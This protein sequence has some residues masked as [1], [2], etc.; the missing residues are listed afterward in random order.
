MSFCRSTHEFASP[1]SLDKKHKRIFPLAFRLLQKISSVTNKSLW[2]QSLFKTCH[3]AAI[4]ETPLGH[5]SAAP[6]TLYGETSNS[7]KRFPKLT[8][9]FHIWNHQWNRTTTV[10]FIMIIFT[11]LLI[12]KYKYKHD[13]ITYN[14]RNVLSVFTYGK[15]TFLVSL[16]Q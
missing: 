11:I 14:V 1:G 9:K 8:I 4:F 16:L 2:F 15:N 7:P 10:F 6:T 12:L 13:I 5:P 3:S